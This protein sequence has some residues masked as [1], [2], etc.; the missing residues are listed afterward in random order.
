MEGDESSETVY[1]G[2]DEDS[3]E[4][5]QERTE[6]KAVLR[7]GVFIDDPLQ[8]FKTSLLQLLITSLCRSVVKL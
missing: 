8:T 2:D 5:D 3:S 7:L 4:S 6:G 1:F